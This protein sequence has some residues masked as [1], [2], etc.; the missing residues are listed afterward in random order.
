[1]KIDFK[2]NLG[3]TT[4]NRVLTIDIYNNITITITLLKIFIY[5]E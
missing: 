1:M 4:N 2:Q 5:H 3:C